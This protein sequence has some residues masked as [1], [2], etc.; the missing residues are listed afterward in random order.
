[1]PCGAS[2]RLL[3]PDQRD[4][5][6]LARRWLAEGRVSLRPCRP[7]RELHLLT[8]IMQRSPGALCPQRGSWSAPFTAGWMASRPTPSASTG[9]T[10]CTFEP[11]TATRRN[12]CCEHRSQRCQGGLRQT[13]KRSIPQNIGICTCDAVDGKYGKI[14][15]V[16]DRSCSMTL[17]S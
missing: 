2:R 4:E 9:L 1:R 16:S 10:A 15:R 6:L 14:T 13:F 8:A 11:L 12:L 5:L 17:C 3:V 7:R